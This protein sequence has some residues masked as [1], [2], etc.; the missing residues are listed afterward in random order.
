MRQRV[1]AKR[2]SGSMIRIFLRDLSAMPNGCG[3]GMR[4]CSVPLADTQFAQERHHGAPV[5][6]CRLEKVQADKRSEQKPVGAD[7]V[8]E[9]QSCEDESSSNHAKITFNGHCSTSE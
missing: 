6:E 4:C 7:P 1:S 5:S 3:G 2:A 9:G 8:A